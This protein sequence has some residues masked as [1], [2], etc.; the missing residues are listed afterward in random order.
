MHLK[1]FIIQKKKRQVIN[2]NIGITII[3]RGEEELNS[4]EP[5]EEE[6]EEHEELGEA[7]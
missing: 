4:E 3:I 5:K 6:Q 2:T 1:V 7:D